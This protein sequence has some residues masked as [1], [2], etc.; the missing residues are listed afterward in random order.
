MIIEAQ[1]QGVIVESSVRVPVNDCPPTGHPAVDNPDVRRQLEV[2]LIA[3]NITGDDQERLEIPGAWWRNNVTGELE[4]LRR[5]PTVQTNCEVVAIPL[6]RSGYTL[7][8]LTHTHPYRPGTLI[9]FCGTEVVAGFYNPFGRNGGGSAED[10]DNV[11]SMSLLHGSTVNGCH[12]DVGYIYCLAPNTPE[13]DRPL[14]SNI[15]VRQ[16]SGC[17]ARRPQ[18]G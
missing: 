10:W 15:F 14:N 7:V 18:G 3:S 4:Y 16:P 11:T 5:T 1:L 9:V 6:P 17:Y 2:D 8:L 12:I 13:A